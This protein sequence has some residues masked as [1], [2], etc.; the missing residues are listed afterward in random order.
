MIPGSRTVRAT[1][2]LGF[3]ALLAPFF[4]E[5]LVFLVPAL[6]GLFA[7]AVIESVQ[8]AH[9]TVSIDRPDS[10][11]LSLG[12]I[13]PYS[14]RVHTTAPYPLRIRLR[15][16]WP[17]LVEQ[18]SSAAE[19]ICRPGEVLRFDFELHA[20]ERGRIAVDSPWARITR[21]QFAERDVRE[22][23]SAELAVTPNLKSV[24]RLHQ[25][26]NQF[27]LRGYGTRA[28]ARLGKG[29]EFDRMRDYV[30]GDDLRDIAWK[31]SARHGKLIV[32]EYRLDRSQDIL[33]CLDSGHRMAA[34]V[35][36][37]SRLD[38]AVNAAMLLAYICN[39]MEDRIGILSFSSTVE[40]GLPTG[41]GPSHLREI[42]SF[43]TGVRPFY[44][45]TDYV[46]LAADLRRRMHHRSLI[47]MMTALPELEDHHALIQAVKV[48]SSQHLVLVMVFADTQLQAASEIL[49]ANKREL[50]RTLVARDLWDRRFTLTRELRMLG[51]LVVDTPPEQFSASAVNAYLDVKRRQ[52]L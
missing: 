21:W 46:A 26:L 28:A 24:A 8:L 5:L 6:V 48:L 17:A 32:R 36:R 41:R 44:R 25:Q 45:H 23:S 34:R 20:I 42:T 49:P 50:A 12:E 38:H 39:R 30:Q 35:G 27:F 22:Q 33:L 2:L 4:P 47:F 31:A 43:V 7:L 9:V 29:R 37:I 13:E 16:P 51:A 52:L 15:Q 14:M 1:T 19:G 11:A 3:F 40:R 18:Q 10:V